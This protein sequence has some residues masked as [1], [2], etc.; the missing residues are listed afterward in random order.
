VRVRI[1]LLTDDGSG[2]PE[3][4]KKSIA[5]G[6]DFA[7]AGDMKRACSLWLG[8]GGAHRTGYALPYL[9]GVCSEYAGDLDEAQR[10]YERANRQSARPVPEIAAALAR[11][12]KARADLPLLDE[13]TR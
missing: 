12:R 4:L 1:P 11:I 9:S 6:V 3:P 10:D 13:Q 5:A 8:A 2:I 7:Q